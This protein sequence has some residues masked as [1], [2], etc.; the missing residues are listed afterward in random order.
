MRHPKA[1]PLLQLHEN[2]SG[3]V[4][5]PTL[6]EVVSLTYKAFGTLSLEHV[7][8]KYFLSKIKAVDGVYTILCWK[9]CGMVVEN[10]R[11]YQ[12]A[13]FVRQKPGQCIMKERPASEG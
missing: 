1:T 9:C 12:L 4:L 5:F 2:V 6:R 13:P 10:R 3:P 7:G 11:S 8:G